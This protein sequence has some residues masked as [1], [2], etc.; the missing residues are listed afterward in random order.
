M[1]KKL[2]VT[3]VSA[4]ASAIIYHYVKEVIEEVADAIDV[5]KSRFNYEFEEEQ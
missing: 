3:V 2:I 4:I 5:D 1:N